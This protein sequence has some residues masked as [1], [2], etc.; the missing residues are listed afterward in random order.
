MNSGEGYL[1]DEGWKLKEVEPEAVAVNGS[2]RHAEGIGPT[3]DFV[4][5]GQ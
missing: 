2:S 4:P 3:V 1:A 5:V